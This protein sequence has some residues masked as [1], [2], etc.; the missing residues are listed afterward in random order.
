MR[1]GRLPDAKAAGLFIF[2]YRQSLSSFEKMHLDKDFILWYKN[3]AIQCAAVAQS[4]ERILGK[5]EVG[6]SNLP[7]S[8]K[9]FEIARFQRLFAFPNKTP[10]PQP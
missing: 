9:A 8:S 5:D 6:S 1:G 2:E 4:A 10:R 3:V 7:S